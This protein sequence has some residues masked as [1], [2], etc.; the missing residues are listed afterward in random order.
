VGVKNRVLVA[1]RIKGIS[2]S[3]KT[4]AI[5]QCAPKNAARLAY[6]K[7]GELVAFE[8]EQTSRSISADSQDALGAWGKCARR[9]EYGEGNTRQDAERIASELERQAEEAVG[10]TDIG[11][12]ANKIT[13]RTANRASG[14]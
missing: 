6:E 11:Q 2:G 4:R 3:L 8:I 14:A 12:I 7:W 10:Q 1:F 9:L 13:G 5:L